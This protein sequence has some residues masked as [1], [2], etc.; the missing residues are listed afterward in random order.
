MLLAFAILLD[1]NRSD[2]SGPGQRESSATGCGGCVGSLLIM[3]LLVGA[4]I[5]IL[6][7]GR[8]DNAAPSPVSTIESAE[9]KVP[10]AELVALPVRRAILVHK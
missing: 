2:V 8:K 7:T 10:R 4:G 3:G 6:N 5:G 1:A 9:P